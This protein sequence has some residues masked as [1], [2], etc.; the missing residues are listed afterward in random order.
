MGRFEFSDLMGVD[1]FKVDISI[2]ADVFL[3]PAN[4]KFNSD[5]KTFT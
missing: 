5:A 1:G 4:K 3:V 2:A